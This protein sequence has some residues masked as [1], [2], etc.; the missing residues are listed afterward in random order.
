MA[1][2][3][4]KAK[5]QED[6]IIKTQTTL[7]KLMAQLE[8]VKTKLSSTK[9]KTKNHEDLK[10]ELSGTKMEM[11]AIRVSYIRRK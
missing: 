3:I 4:K 5:Y 9:K 6:S 10:V 2:C 11:K 8:K 1:S 7:N